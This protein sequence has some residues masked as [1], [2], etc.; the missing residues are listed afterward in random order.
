V[1]GKIARVLVAV[2][3]NSTSQV[4]LEY[5]TAL[6]GHV[7]ATMHLL[8]VVESPLAAGPLTAEVYIAAMP[9]AR[10]RLLDE[11]TARLAGLVAST[12]RESVHATSEVRAGSAADII[13]NVAG[14]RQSDLIVIG[15]HG[16]TGLA[17]LLV[18][19]VAE[20][21]VRQAPCPVLTVRSHGGATIAPARSSF[22]DEL[23]WIE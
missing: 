7:G 6:A 2:D 15:T 4:A 12:Q 11:A 1:A 10:N 16:R 17:H 3:F 22:V 19:S 18:G 8:H 20:L 13:C 5:A 14:E 23:V 9:A 21:V